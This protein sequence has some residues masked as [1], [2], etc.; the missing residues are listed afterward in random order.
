MSEKVKLC[1]EK[2]F[3]RR[4]LL[5]QALYFLTRLMQLPPKGAQFSKNDLLEQS[6][7]PK[8]DM[9]YNGQSFITIT[10]SAFNTAH[11]MCGELNN[12]SAKKFLLNGLSDFL[13]KLE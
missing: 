13:F 12:V 5:L 8:M 7:L 6:S 2:H 4:V 3:R 9:Q 1:Y 11:I 10:K